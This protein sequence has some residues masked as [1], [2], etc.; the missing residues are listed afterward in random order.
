[1]PES[2]AIAQPSLFGVPP[3]SE[4]ERMVEAMLFASPAPLSL[5]ELAPVCPRAVTPRRPL[6]CCARL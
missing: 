2:D 4:Q 1:M 5:S 3:L 6:T